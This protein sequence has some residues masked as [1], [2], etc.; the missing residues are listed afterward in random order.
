MGQC[1]DLG[2]LLRTARWDAGLRQTDLARL[3][4]TS[5]ST[6]NAYE[7]GRK[8]PSFDTLDRLLAAMDRQLRLT[9]EP[10]QADVDALLAGAGDE[11][12]W[13]RLQQEPF[14]EMLLDRIEAGNFGYAVTGACAALLHG[15]ALPAAGLDI[16]VAETALDVVATLLRE[17]RPEHW[18]TEQGGWLFAPPIS[19]HLVESPASRWTTAY[20]PLRVHVR[21]TASPTIWLAAGGRR[22]RVVALPAVEVD[23]PALR[24]LLDRF[25]DQQPA[26]HSRS[27]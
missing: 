22:L 1:S 18:C 10:R 7:R 5:Q 15:V 19:K 13:Q 17:S 27:C 20:G 16:E 6:I 12:G 4:G 26:D 14:I 21:R 9:V 25:R 24:R 2:A 23:D 3:A 8:V 11:D